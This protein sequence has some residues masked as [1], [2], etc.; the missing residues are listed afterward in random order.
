MRPK[1]KIQSGLWLTAV[2]LL[3]CAMAFSQENREK[4]MPSGASPSQSAKKLPSDEYLLLGNPNRGAGEPWVVVNPKD[5]N[6]ILVVAMATLNRLPSGEGPIRPRPRPGQP[7]QIGTPSWTSPETLLRVKELSVPDG[8]RTDIAVTQDG[9]KTWSFSQD[10]FRKVFDKN[11]CSDSFAGA[12]ANGTLY[13]G[14]IAYLNRGNADY[15]QGYAPNGE[16]HYYHG[17]SAMAWSTDKG[18]TWSKP[19]WVHPAF[20]ASLYAPTVKPVLEQASPWDRPVFVADAS[21]GTIYVSGMGLAYTADPATVQRPKLNPKLPGQG[22]TGYPPSSVTR[23]RTLIRA[24]HDGG[25][26]WSLIYPMDSDE[27]PGFVG[28]YGFSAAFGHFVDAYDASKVPEANEKCPCTVLGISND[29]GKTF[30]HKLVPPLP[31][32]ETG[33]G[34]RSFCGLSCVMLSADPSREGRYAIARQAGKRIL[35]SLTEDGGNTWAAPV[36]AAEVPSNAMFEH[37]AMKYSPTGDLG[38]V[39]EAVYPDGTFD[40]WS[41]VWLDGGHSFKTVRVSHALSPEC[42]RDRCNF[43]MGD[44]L[45][46]MDIDRKFLYAVWGDNR[47]GFEGTWFG[48]VPLSAYK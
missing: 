4:S 48:Q 1:K 36:V 40:E 18:K 21:T 29:S 26:T 42:V 2:L 46:S 43:M 44:D 30:V 31:K 16:A 28:V 6:N 19:I 24:S 5:P 23:M 11:R 3:S 8:S 14:C 35:V 13:M 17:G 33:A 34:A 10:D 9:G 7:F 12:A 15:A 25:R 22:Y 20:S 45:S 41:S 47:S 38:L 32:E 39:W 27:Y 37:L